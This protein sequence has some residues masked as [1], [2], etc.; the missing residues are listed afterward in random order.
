[1]AR[2]KVIIAYDGT[3]FQGYQRQVKA[4][5]VQGVLEDALRQLNW[6]SRSILSAGRTDTG[7]HALGQVVAFDL[8]WDRLDEDLR[9]SLNALLPE[10][11]AARSVEQVEACF[12]PRYDA[13]LRRYRY[14]IFCDPVRDPL[15]ER[16]AWR[17]WPPV[18]VA[19]LKRAASYL[20]GE[21]NFAAFGTPP[22]VGDSTVRTIQK[23][24]WHENGFSQARINEIIFE[25]E[26]ES[27]LYHMVRRLVYW[28]VLI[29]QER[30]KVDNLLFHLEH[31]G[32][33][34]LPEYAAIQGLSPACGLV[35]LEVCYPNGADGGEL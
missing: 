27:F 20:V 35:L 9:K 2:Y 18:N 4:R 5:T 30:Y 26:A 28:Q 12:H 33:R 17:I 3:H 23:A 29:A 10:D 32:Q 25:I 19:E 22:R 8:A 13:I 21:H 1:M 16:Y 34:G 15:R 24:G 31:P 14:H 6:D 7:V 11:V